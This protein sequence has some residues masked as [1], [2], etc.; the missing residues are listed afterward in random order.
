MRDTNEIKIMAEPQMDQNV[1]RFIVDRT[2]HNGLVN[3]KNEK[4]AKGSPL[5]EALF[6]LG[7]IR[8]VMVAGGA[9]TIAKRNETEWHILGKEIGRV[10]RETISSGQPL[11][12]E[13]SLN[14]DQPSNPELRAKVQTVFDEEINPGLESH[15]GSADVIDAKGNTVFITMSGGCQGCASA[16]QTLRYGIER[17]LHERVPEIEEIIDITDHSAGVNPYY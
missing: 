10:I 1:C 12:D 2:V 11:I 5:L 16:T 4:T 7:G 13:A 17:I 8:E 3:C 6:A 9:I 15:G 14:K